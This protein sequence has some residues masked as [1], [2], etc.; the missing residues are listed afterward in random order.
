MQYAMTG[1]SEMAQLVAAAAI[2]YGVGAF[3]VG[4]PFGNDA[5]CHS[6]HLCKYAHKSPTHP[7]SSVNL[8]VP[9]Q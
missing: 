6:D 4:Q 2:S 3:A 5:L 9:L 7:L 8:Q 1:T